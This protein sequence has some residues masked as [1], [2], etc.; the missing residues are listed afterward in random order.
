MRRRRLLLLVSVLL[1]ASGAAGEAFPQ[2][3]GHWVPFRVDEG[4]APGRPA[5]R[6]FD[7]LVAAL[8]DRVGERET[9]LQ[10]IG[11]VSPRPIDRMGPS[12]RFGYWQLYLT[13]IRSVDTKLGPEATGVRGSFLDTLRALPGEIR[14]DP[15]QAAESLGRIFQPQ[16]NLGIEF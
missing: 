10:E 3:I 2:S 4:L 7:T 11:Q 9:A 14:N 13:R 6:T 16:L 8:S 1:L 12:L 5:E 15:T